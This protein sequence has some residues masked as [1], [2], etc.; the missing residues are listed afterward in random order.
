MGTQE[1]IIKGE[2]KGRGKKT[3]KTRYRKSTLA[4]LRG[5]NSNIREINN[6]YIKKLLYELQWWWQII[7]FPCQLSHRP[8]LFF[9]QSDLP[10]S[11]PLLCQ[12]L[13]QKEMT[14]RRTPPM[15]SIYLSI[16]LYMYLSINVSIL[17]NLCIHPISLS[18]QSKHTARSIR[19]PSHGMS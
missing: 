4:Q 1:V 14:S 2:E 8:D 10:A 15:L 11:Q 13:L 6:S 5:S 7:S 18:P 3:K 19:C 12:R 9:S 16:Y 17:S